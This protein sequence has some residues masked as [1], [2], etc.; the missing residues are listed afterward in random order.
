[1]AQTFTAGVSGSLTDVVLSVVVSNPRNPMAIVP[2]DA[3]GRPVVAIPLAS[4]TLA[5]DASPT[6]VD[7]DVSFPTPARV[8][9]GKQ[10]AIVLY[11]P[12][13]FAWAWKADLGGTKPSCQL[14]L[15]RTSSVT[16]IFAKK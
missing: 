12:A 13:E 10:Y 6:F 9:A 11:A 7:V 14:T 1:V 16:A 3:G 4:T 5:V 2:V 8:E 15:S